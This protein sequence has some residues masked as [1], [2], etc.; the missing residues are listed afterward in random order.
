[1]IENISPLTDCH[2]TRIDS[3]GVIKSFGYP[4][5]Y[6]NNIHCTWLIQ[7]Q[8]GLFIEV[9]FITFELEDGATCG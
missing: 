2:E 1:M 5:K 8:E 3:I 7:I 6:Y 9:I 4:E